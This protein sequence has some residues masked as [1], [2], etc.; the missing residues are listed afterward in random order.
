MKLGEY[1]SQLKADLEAAESLD[2]RWNIGDAINYIR[3]DYEETSVTVL[4]GLLDAHPELW[5]AI[6]SLE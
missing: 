3:R 4:E 6:N 2:E 5:E 1:Y